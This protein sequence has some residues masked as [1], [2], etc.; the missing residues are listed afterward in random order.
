MIFPINVP[1]FVGFWSLSLPLC[2]QRAEPG[3]HS[4]A[5]PIPAGCTCAAAPGNCKSRRW[6][7]VNLPGDPGPA[8][9]VPRAALQSDACLTGSC[10]CFMGSQHMFPLK[11]GNGGLGKTPRLRERP[12]PRSPSGRWLF[13]AFSSHLGCALDAVQRL[14]WLCGRGGTREHTPNLFLME[15]CHARLC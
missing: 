15:S 7:L 12:Q 2:T 9:R 14:G 13:L 3:A 1:L 11:T 4:P 10:C 8:G 6:H 5:P